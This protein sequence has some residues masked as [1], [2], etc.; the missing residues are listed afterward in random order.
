MAHGLQV[1]KNFVRR[2]EDSGSYVS[3]SQVDSCAEHSGHQ[4]I[5]WA[6]LGPGSTS[7]MQIMS[8]A[9]ARGF[10]ILTNDLDFGIRLGVTMQPAQVLFSFDV[11]MLVLRS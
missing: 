4:A 10:T 6:L 1:K 5:H 8:F 9:A 3:V 2:R 11:R 7:D